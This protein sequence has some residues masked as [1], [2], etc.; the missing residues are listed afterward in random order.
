MKKLR[1]CLALF[2]YIGTMLL[3]SLTDASKGW[4]IFLSAWWGGTT[5]LMIWLT[6]ESG[7]YRFHLPKPS[8]KIG[9]RE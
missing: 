7:F 3:F 9:D 8:K 1:F 6:F 2:I 4:F 5:I